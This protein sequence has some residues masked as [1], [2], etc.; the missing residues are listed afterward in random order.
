MHPSWRDFPFIIIIFPSLRQIDNPLLT[1][2]SWGWS[3]HR[4][5]APPHHVNAMMLTFWA[6]W[7][8]R[9][10]SRALN[11]LKGKPTKNINRNSAKGHLTTNKERDSPQSSKIPLLSS[12]WIPQ[13]RTLGR[14]LYPPSSKSYQGKTPTAATEHR[15][16][17]PKLLLC[18]L[19][20]AV[21]TEKLSDDIYQHPL[22]QRPDLWITSF[23]SYS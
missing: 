22:Q 8:P 9:T 20:S 16:V 15:S 5:L 2:F 12:A 7:G 4:I 14:H 19:V 17:F 13:V 11:Y 3:Q 6:S 18:I 21:Y 1:C 10:A 23:S